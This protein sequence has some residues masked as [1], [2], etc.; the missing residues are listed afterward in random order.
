ME[1]RDVGQKMSHCCPPYSADMII[2]TI[3]II[4]IVII[5][6]FGEGK[7]LEGKMPKHN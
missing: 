6:H 7:G 3:T 1:V 2:T 5:G 4:I